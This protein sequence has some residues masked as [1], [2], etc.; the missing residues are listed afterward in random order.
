MI[1]AQ[2]HRGPDD[3][4]SEVRKLVSCVV[5]LGHCRLAILDVSPQ[6]HQP[7]IHPE[8]SDVLVYNGEIYNFREL[9]Q[10]LVAQGVKFRG[11]SDTEVLLHGLTRW[12]SEYVTRLRGMFAFAFLSARDRR[13]IVARDPLGIK[14]LYQATMPDGLLMASEVGGILATGW[15]KRRLDTQ[16]LGGL[17][18]YGAL[19]APCTLY[20]DIRSFVPGAVQEIDLDTVFEGPVAR[21]RR[22]F[23]FPRP[24]PDMSSPQAVAMVRK[25]VD[26]AVQEHLISDVPLGVFLSSGV[27]STIIAG[28]VARCSPQVRAFTLSF[29]EDPA[30]SEGELACQTARGIGLPHQNIE[31]SAAAAEQA[32][33]RWL[34]TLDLPSMDGL[35]V[36]ILSQVVKQAGITVAL[37]GQ[38][39]DEVFGGYPSFRD[40]PRL[41]RIMQL[42][43]PLPRTLRQRAA[44]LM[45]PLKGA[46]FAHKLRD[47][48]GTE[49]D[50]AEL[51][52]C[53]RRVS[54]QA[55]LSEFGL[56][57]S[58]LGLD[59]N[60]LP[61]QSPV[62]TD[63]DSDDP[64]WS[65]ARLESRFYLGNM[66][67]RDSDANGMRHSLEI[68][69]PFLDTGLLQQLQ[70]IPGPLRLP[71]PNRPKHLL[72]L[73]FPELL[74]PHVIGQRKRGFTLPISRWMRT[75]LRAH[76]ESALDMLKSADVLKPQGVNAIW[77][78]FLRAPQS[79][80]WSRA[81]NLVV[82]GSYLKRT[83][84]HR[85]GS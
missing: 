11:E 58:E 50:L 28:L 5:G 62:T 70:T 43:K 54:S 33:Y 51:Y 84:L 30:L 69:V 56:L 15:V 7:M 18:A 6:G 26:R 63:V 45:A 47:I 23:T 41:R 39:G 16:G 74:P 32:C 31:I 60:F 53:R 61:P 65:M 67:L 75:S 9:R 59:P 40:V 22:Y 77:Q 76:C 25:E 83:G 80:I 29:A 37:S 82:L 42:L 10:E 68:R 44:W 52:F 3:D 72:R 20:Q 57:A 14:F 55:Q 38:G 8:T 21:P 79:A 71:D 64:V 78:E 66:L 48:L 34:A 85:C 73:A 27:D 17:M 24:N 2:R 12:G 35:N 19:Q 4:G 49:G 13:L 36:F 46:A 1:D 81:F